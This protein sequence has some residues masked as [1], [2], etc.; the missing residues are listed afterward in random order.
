MLERILL[1]C[2]IKYFRGGAEGEGAKREHS[3][4]RGSWMV[5]K[6]HNSE[7]FGKVGFHRLDV[8][9]IVLSL[10]C[11]FIALMIGLNA[12]VYRHY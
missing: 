10:S 12:L 2:I 6:R 7:V 3:G 9:F 8:V 5:F 1:R 4:R 11:S